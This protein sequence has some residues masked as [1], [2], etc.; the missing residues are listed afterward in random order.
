VAERALA[1]GGHRHR[2]RRGG[3]RRRGRHEVAQRHQRVDGFGA[4]Q[5]AE[6]V[7]AEGGGAAREISRVEISR[8]E[9]SRGS[10]QPQRLRV[11]PR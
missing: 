6:H 11:T 4:G 10:H 5:R 1:H 7:R 3:E 8:V 2:H 9:I